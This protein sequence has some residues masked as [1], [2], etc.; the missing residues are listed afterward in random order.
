VAVSSSDALLLEER[1]VESVAVEHFCELRIQSQ[2]AK[3]LRISNWTTSGREAHGMGEEED[4]IAEGHECVLHA[5]KRKRVFTTTS[6]T[7]C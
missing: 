4:V 2:T 1:L 3:A 6:R 5:L 7:N